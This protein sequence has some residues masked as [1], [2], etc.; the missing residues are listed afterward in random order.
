V[1]EP[2]NPGK[3]TEPSK[4]PEFLRTKMTEEQERKD[5]VLRVDR[6]RSFSRNGLETLLDRQSRTEEAIKRISHDLDNSKAMESIKMKK[7]RT[8]ESLAILT[9]K[10]EQAN[11]LPLLRTW[12]QNDRKGVKTDAE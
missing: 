1:F 8:M 6:V 7:Q 2:V 10:S 9:R 11:G 12:K 3:A 4:L 5:E